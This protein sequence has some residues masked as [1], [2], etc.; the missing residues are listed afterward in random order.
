LSSLELGRRP[1]SATLLTGNCFRS[2]LDQTGGDMPL[3]SPI[4]YLDSSGLKHC[5]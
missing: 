2:W 4:L 5:R 1:V 3:G